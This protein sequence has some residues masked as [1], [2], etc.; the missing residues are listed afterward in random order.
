MLSAAGSTTQHFTFL[1]QQEGRLYHDLLTRKFT[2]M[3]NFEIGNPAADEVYV[4]QQEMA[5]EQVWQ[6]AFDGT[7][8]GKVLQPWSR[9]RESL[10]LRLTDNE[11]GRDHLDDLP[12]MQIRLDA[13]LKEKQEAQIYKLRDV[14]NALLYIEQVALVLFLATRKPEQWDYLRGNKAAFL[15]AASDWAEAEIADGKEWDAI[16]CVQALRGDYKR[17]VATRVESSGERRGDLGN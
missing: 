8:N 13:L 3:L 9:A 14:T 4:Q 1:N 11:E 10:F 15:R 12:L 2:T 7:W 16:E 6:R 17:L 5:R